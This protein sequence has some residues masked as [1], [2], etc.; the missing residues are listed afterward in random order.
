MSGEET[1]TESLAAEGVKEGQAI[2]D[3]SK[4]VIEHLSK[5]IETT[6]TNMM[7]YRSKIAFAVFLGPFLLLLAVVANTRGL[8]ISL[9]LGWIA[10]VAIGIVWCFCFLTLAFMNAR[11]EPQ[12]WAAM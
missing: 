12:A 2:Q 5:E 1:T 7:V 8:S 6:T 10:T 3:L 11:I 4:E 9:N